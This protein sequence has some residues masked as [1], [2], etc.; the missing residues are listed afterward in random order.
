[1]HVGWSSP[2]VSWREGA[3]KCWPKEVWRG[4]SSNG[5]LDTGLVLAPAHSAA[6][7][8]GVPAAPAPAGA[9]GAEPSGPSCLVFAWKSAGGASFLREVGSQGGLALTGGAITSDR[10]FTCPPDKGMSLVGGRRFLAAQ[11]L[12]APRLERP[13][14]YPN[15]PSVWG[16]GALQLQGS[17]FL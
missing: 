8:A 5:S 9:L 14:P 1:M 2:R 13:G 17:F 4:V 10:P 12:P 16:R 6:P 7:W 11:V 15:L 3:D